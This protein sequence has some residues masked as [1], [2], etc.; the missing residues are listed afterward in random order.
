VKFNVEQAMKARRGGRG[1]ALLFLCPRF[2][3]GVGTKNM[4]LKKSIFNMKNFK[5]YSFHQVLVIKESLR[6]SNTGKS[7]WAEAFG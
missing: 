5:I 6:S 2:Q 3:M 7:V 4:S 1:I